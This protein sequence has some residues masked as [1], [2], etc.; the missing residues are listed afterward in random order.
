M[1]GKGIRC[2]TSLALLQLH[3]FLGRSFWRR[4]AVTR[5]PRRGRMIFAGV[6]QGRVARKCAPGAPGPVSILQDAV[7]HIRGVR[8]SAIGSSSRD[9]GHAEGFSSPLGL[10]CCNHGSGV[11]QTRS[12]SARSAQLCAWAEARRPGGCPQSNADSPAA[13]VSGPTIDFPGSMANRVAGRTF[14]EALAKMRARADRGTTLTRT[15]EG[16]AI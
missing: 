6:W 16:G 11:D 3:T 5:T 8:R 1:A 13:R 7:S 14:D 10:P 4:C 12:R 9:S 15:G 2:A